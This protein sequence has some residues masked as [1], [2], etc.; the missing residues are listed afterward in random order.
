MAPRTRGVCWDSV[1][2]RPFTLRQRMRYRFDNSLSRGIWGVLVWLGVLALAFFFIIALFILITGIGP[3]GEPTTFPEALWYAL[4]RSLDPGTFSGDEGLGFRLVMLVV[5]LTGI[6]LAAAIIGLVSSSIDRRLDNLRRGRSLVVEEGHTLILGQSDKLTPIISELI[7]ANASEKDRAI[8]VLTP[9]DT[10]DVSDSIRGTIKDFKTSRLVVRSGQPTRLAELEQGNPATARSIIVLRS[11]SDAQVV[12]TTLGVLRCIGPDSSATI[13]VEL[14]DPDTAAAL[15][16]AGDGRIIAVTSSAIVALIGAQVA[17]APGLG[18]IYQE[19]LDFDG[20]ELYSIAVTAPWLGR[21]FG[22]ALFA[23]SRG[24][25]IGMRDAN[26]ATTIAPDPATILHEGDFLIGIAEDDSVFAL[27]LTPHDWAP[28]PRAEHRRPANARERTLVIGWSPLAPR[29]ARELD[30]HVASGSELHLLVNE[31]LE[32]VDAIRESMTLN[33]QELAIRVGDPISR[34]AVAAALDTGTFDHVLLLSESGVYNSEE[35]DARTMLA[36]LHVHSH[37]THTQAPDNVVAELLDPNDVELT[38]AAEN[39]DFIVSQRL[40]ALLMAQLS[41][42]PHLQ[43]VFE[44]IFDS[45]GA[46]IV[47]HPASLYVPPGR[48]TFGAIV[49]AARERGAVALGYRSAAAVGQPGT[50]GNGIRL[51]APKNDPV[52]LTDGD[53]VILIDRLP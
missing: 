34:S 51:N 17:R 35:A 44:E 22:E 27:D 3:G 25:I 16:S 32:M 29:I 40:I 9:D 48:T 36:L 26:G 33:N 53:S 4:T 8:V 30:R 14:E 15:E 7:E 5:T 39:R 18:A 23:S 11:E 2:N 43:P 12:K 6:F 50:I 21:T 46:N 10:V 37:A 42:S 38:G 13:V 28:D 49:E 41:E 52:D 24:T 1:V 20:D 31:P 19:L 45:D 47:V